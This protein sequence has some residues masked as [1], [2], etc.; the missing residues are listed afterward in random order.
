MTT[1]QVPTQVG[2]MYCVSKLTLILILG[3]CVAG[4]FGLKLLS[5]CLFGDAAVTAEHMESSGLG[6]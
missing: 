6:E 2:Q 5:Y 1:T 4:V 3:P